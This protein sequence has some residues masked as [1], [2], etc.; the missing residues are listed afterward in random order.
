MSLVRERWE[1]EEEFAAL[2]EEIEGVKTY[3]A[4][5][6]AHPSWPVI[7]AGKAG[8]AQTF[9][10]G[11]IPFWVKTP[12]DAR[13]IRSKT[14]NSRSETAHQL[15]SF[16]SLVHARRCIIPVDGFFEPF[17]LDK[18]SYPFYIHRKDGKPFALG[19]LWDANEKL[20]AGTF[21]VLTMPAAGLIAEIHNE[22]LRMPLMLSGELYSQWTDPGVPWEEAKHQAWEA[23][24]RMTGELSAYPVGPLL[25]SRGRDSNIPEVRSPFTYNISE[26]DRLAAL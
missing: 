15:P 17:R 25:Y 18:K 3:Q 11:L 5:G 4:S 14:L 24:E 23:A 22:K 1:L 20:G 26:V 16:R 21:T 9:H 19:G 13:S 12:E 6:F 2:F 7:P 10:W 8:N